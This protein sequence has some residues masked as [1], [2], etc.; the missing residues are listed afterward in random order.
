M[1]FIIICF[2]LEIM[3]NQ[4]IYLLELNISIYIHTA[5]VCN[6]WA[7]Y[8][9]FTIYEIMYDIIS[10]AKEKNIDHFIFCVI[11]KLCNYIILIIKKV[12]YKY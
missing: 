6:T 7:E 5:K 9:R 11:I 8:S 12:L 1:V 2:K 10:I 4:F 3:Y